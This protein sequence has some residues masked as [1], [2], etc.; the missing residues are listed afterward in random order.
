MLL[1][2]LAQHCLHRARLGLSPPLTIHSPMPCRLGMNLD[3]AL[4]ESANLTP[5]VL[6]AWLATEAERD[7]A[8]WQPQR[9]DPAPLAEEEGEVAAGEEGGGSAARVQFRDVAPLLLGL[10]LGG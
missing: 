1:L 9:C 3:A 6:S 5:P 2:L 10:G 8:Q 4:E 7:A